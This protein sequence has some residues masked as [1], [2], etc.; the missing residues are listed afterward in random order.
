[1]SDGSG[2][3]GLRRSCSAILVAIC[4]AMGRVDEDVKPVWTREVAALMPASAM[5]KHVCSAMR[6]HPSASRTDL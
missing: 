5:P 6:T 2:G 4:V 1:M 3:E